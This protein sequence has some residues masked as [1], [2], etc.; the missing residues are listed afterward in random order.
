MSA[1]RLYWYR[2]KINYGDYLSYY[3]VNKIT[4]SHVKYVRPLSGLKDYFK[5][6]LGRGGTLLLP[7]QKHYL[8][9]GTILNKANK[10]SI[11]W[12]SG[13]ND[14]FDRTK[15]QRIIAVRGELSKRI[16]K[17]HNKEIINDIRVGDPALLLPKF[18]TP[19][20]LKKKYRL[21][22]IPH[23][24]DDGYFRALNKQYHIISVMTT[25]VEAFVDEIV[26]SEYVLSSSL[27][28]IITAH[29]YGI[30]AL[31]IRNYGIQYT[32][33]KFLDYFS[34]VEISLYM[35][36]TNVTEI[37]DNEEIAIELFHANRERI[38]PSREKIEEIHENLM[39]C[40]PFNC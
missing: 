4:S 3:I 23:Y 16:I 1:I 12:G 15:A 36:F 8:C 10:Y 19:N 22:I 25:D 34:S 20:N 39:R 30:P 14:F 29:A 35:G 26:S 18:Y 13:F 40:C 2:G 33:F 21:S 5:F 27:H 11:V 6:F 9:I 37:F 28:G 38:L 31:W 24:R 17:E 32:G 7:W